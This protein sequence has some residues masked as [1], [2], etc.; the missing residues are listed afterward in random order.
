[1]DEV[2]SESVYQILLIPT[3]YQESTIPYSKME[4]IL[5]QEPNPLLPQA[6][7]ILD[8]LNILEPLNPSQFR[9]S[10]LSNPPSREYSTQSISTL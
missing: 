1:M 7:V 8:F 2:E 5:L 10:S 9:A 4:A 6:L 3:C